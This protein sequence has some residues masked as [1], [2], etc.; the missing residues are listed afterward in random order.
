M[1]G[2]HSRS[3]GARIEREIVAIHDEIPCPA[4]KVS[5]S[6]Y[7]GEDLVIADE[8]SAE[9]K[10]RSEGFKLLDRWLGDNSLL[11]IRKDGIR[12]PGVYMPWR[13]YAQ[14]MAAYLELRE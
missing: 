13:V 7:T 11:F 9:V 1:P 12:Y 8:F 4:E 10:A 5:R 2:K 3:K 6:G 14:L